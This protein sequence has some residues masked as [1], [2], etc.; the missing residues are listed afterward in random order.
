MVGF[1]VGKVGWDKE[2]FGVFELGKYKERSKDRGEKENDWDRFIDV[3]GKYDEGRNG[4]C[5]YRDGEFDN[6]MEKDW[7]R[8]RERFEWDCNW[9]DFE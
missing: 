3:S 8:E 7:L 5:V 2:E 9:Y 6:D 4:Y 1:G